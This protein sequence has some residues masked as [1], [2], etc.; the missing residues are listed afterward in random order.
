MIDKWLSKTKFNKLLENFVKR[1]F[2][3]KISANQITI[4]ALTFGLLSALSIFLSEKLIWSLEL[5]ITAVVLMNISFLLD[6]LDGALARL[7]GTTIFG[8]IL[9]I[10]SDRTVEVSI[11]ISIIS[12]DPLV[13][14]WPGIFSLGAIVLC[15]T[16]FLLVGGTV[17]TEKLEE[18][19]KVIYYRGGLMERSETFISLLLITVIVP[20]RGIILWVFAML[21]LLTAILRLRDAYKI[22]KA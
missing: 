22:F 4:I 18:T 16:M 8:G 17:K 12:T 13:L 15:V 3:N 6:A 9:D 21:V 14:M 20:W 1:L 11:I 19:K 5:I 2:F 7:E 10:I